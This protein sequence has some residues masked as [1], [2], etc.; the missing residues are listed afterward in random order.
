MGEIAKKLEDSNCVDQVAY[1]PMSRC[2][3]DIGAKLDAAYHHVM[4]SNAFILGPMVETF[5]KEFAAFCGAK[6]CIGVANGLDA[7]TL[8]LK[9][10]DIGEGDKV[11]CATNSFVA[12]ALGVSNTGATPVLV[13]ANEQTYNIDPQA[14]EAAITP[15][16]KAIALTHLYGQ[17]ADMDAINAIGVKHNLKVLEDA[18]QAH[19]AEYKGKRAGN[20]GDAATFSFYPTKNLGAYGDAGAVT[21]NDDQLAEKLR[22]LRNYGARVKYHHDILGMN[23]RLD[24]LQAGFLSVKLK[25]LEGWNEK[26]RA[27]AAIYH[28]MLGTCEGL[29]LPHVP[30]WAQPV[31][32]VYSIRVLEGQRAA[33]IKHLEAHNIGYNIHYPVPIHAQE[34]YADLGLS[35]QAFPIASSQADELLSLPCDPYHSSAEIEYVATKIKEFFS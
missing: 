21:T 30:D 28:I 3:E 16:T 18:A 32:H 15:R 29:V 13:E 2:Y 26:R 34:C 7:I 8:C 14:I 35:D 25:H 9:A 1:I 33:L 5:E 4:R 17:C 24:P 27:L 11:I 19:G 22:I 6:H 10:W 31:W 12:T 23:S 20:L